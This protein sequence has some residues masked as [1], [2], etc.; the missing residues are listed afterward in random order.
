MLSGNV[1]IWDGEMLC[2]EW[3]Q[4]KRCRDLHWRYYVTK[5]CWKWW[6]I[7]LLMS[8]ESN[9]TKLR[10]KNFVWSMLSSWKPTLEPSQFHPTLPCFYLFY[11]KVRF[12]VLFSLLIIF[13]S[14]GAFLTPRC[15]CFMVC[16]IGPISISFHY[17]FSIMSQIIVKSS[18]IKQIST[19]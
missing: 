9:P 12:S 19:S 11:R 2:E 4:K 10:R 5:K 13:S 16:K 3:G 18:V 14:I 15:I 7:L 6:E 17:Q 8:G 1:A